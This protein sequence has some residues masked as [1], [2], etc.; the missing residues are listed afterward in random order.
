M[1]FIAEKI[2]TNETEKKN[3]Q[4]THFISAGLKQNFRN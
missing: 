1:L 4:S 2:S 3:R